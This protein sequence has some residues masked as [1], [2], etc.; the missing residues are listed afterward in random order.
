MW[1]A[2]SKQIIGLQVGSLWVYPNCKNRQFSA[3]QRESGRE[4]DKEAGKEGEKLI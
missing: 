1:K 2:T 3:G 4:V